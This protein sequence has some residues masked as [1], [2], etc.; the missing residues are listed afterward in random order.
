MRRTR[1]K[2]LIVSIILSIFIIVFAGST[3]FKNVGRTFVH[4]DEP[5]WI[6]S[7]Y[8][9]SNLLLDG[10]FKWEQWKCPKCEA[11]GSEYN[12][13]LGHWVF[14]ISMKFFATKNEQEFFDMYDPEKSLD[15]NR[16]EGKIPSQPILFRARMSSVAI[17]ILCCLI[18]FWIGYYSS[19]MQIGII[20]SILLTFNN[21]FIDLST[22]AMTDIPYN[23][24]L[25]CACFTSIF[26][27]HQYTSRNR[28]LVCLIYG[29]FI[30]LAS[31][32]KITGVIIGAL[33]FL[34]IILYVKNI[35]G[36]RFKDTLKYLLTFFVSTFFIIYLLNPY[37]WPSF[38]EININE[39]TSEVVTYFKNNSG[40]NVS[41]ENYA[42]EYP[43]L[44]N[45]SHVLEF[46]RM[47]QRFNHLMDEQ[48]NKYGW[49]GDNR[50]RTFHKNLLIYS[51]GLSRESYLLSIGVIL[52][53]YLLVAGIIVLSKNLIQ[54]FQTKKISGSVIPLTYFV[55]NYVFIM[56]FMKLN[57]D[58][59]YLPTVIASQSIMAIGIHATIKLIW[60][61]RR[62]LGETH[63]A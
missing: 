49:W 12:P 26:L 47:F 40:L 30:G 27:L 17:G 7:G 3:L 62:R 56:I 11:F 10:N 54:S 15:E 44:S 2:R 57:W 52:E 16:R 45:L 24:F 25:L 55:A 48:L 43:Q 61:I 5:G 20:A 39:T 28:L 14:G 23:F 21:L 35:F 37:S 58:R 59:Y 18:I 32:V 31:S 60:D 1:N 13:H 22:L 42:V 46:P 51:S 41:E 29:S 33:Y 50:F 36:L 38:T 53:F 4:V 9:Y 19:N 6:S 63:K 8:Y 34:S